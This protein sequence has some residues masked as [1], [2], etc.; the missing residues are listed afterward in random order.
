MSP[1][2][3]ALILFMVMLTINAMAMSLTVGSHQWQYIPLNAVGLFISGTGF[4][5]VAIRLDR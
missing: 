3:R 2:L 4:I 1:D 5:L